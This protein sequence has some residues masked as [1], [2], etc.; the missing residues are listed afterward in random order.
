[1]PEMQVRH[2]SRQV[3]E[4]MGRFMRET[5]TGEMCVLDETGDLRVTWNARDTDEVSA[6]QAQ[7]DELQGKRF[8]AFAVTEEGGQG[9]QIQ[10]FDPNA[11]KIIMVPPMAGG[12]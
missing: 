6:A 1:M 11:Q 2:G 3:R 7:F 8:L 9:E 10:E 5:S 4:E 12:A